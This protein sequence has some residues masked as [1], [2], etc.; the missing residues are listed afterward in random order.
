MVLVGDRSIKKKRT[1]SIP[2]DDQ[3]HILTTFSFLSCLDA[4]ES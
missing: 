1:Q 4:T 2:K 3:I